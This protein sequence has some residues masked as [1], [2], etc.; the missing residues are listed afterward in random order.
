M[1]GWQLTTY[2]YHRVHAALFADCSGDSVLAPLTG[3]RFR[4]G[5]EARSEYSEHIEPEQADHCTMGMSCLLQAKETDHKVEFKPP[6]WA[7][8]Y[9][10][11]EQINRAHDF[12]KDKTENFWWIELGGTG[13][14]IRDTEE[15][16]DELLRVTFGVWDHIKNRGNHGADNWELDWVGFLP[17]KRESR[18]YIGDAVLTEN[19]VASGGRFEDLA[20]YG[21]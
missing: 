19:D 3:A 11:D 21:G 20:A 15:L 14:C 4:M 7:Y 5:R 8:V 9:E 2:R 16:R 17:G 18:R 1:T 10:T 13:D 6:K 12:I